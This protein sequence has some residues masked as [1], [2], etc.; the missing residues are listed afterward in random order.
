MMKYYR[1][2]VF[3]LLALS[4]IIVSGCVSVGPNAVE[5]DRAG[6]NGAIADSWKSQML[7]NIVKMR[8]GDAPIY[9]DVAS[10]TNSDE[11]SGLTNPGAS[12]LFSLRIGPE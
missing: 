9:L 10:V 2:P 7:L 1:R 3:L 12:F 6:Y 4:A 8:Y 5:R 11:V